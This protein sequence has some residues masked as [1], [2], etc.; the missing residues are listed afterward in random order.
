MA[1]KEAKQNGSNIIIKYDNTTKSVQGQLIGSSANAVFVK[2]N[3]TLFI[4]VYKNGVVNP[5][6]HNINL[7]GNED[8]KMYGNKVGIKKPSNPTVHLYDETGHSAGTTIAR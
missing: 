8:I 3:R 7:T 6:G 1:I 5:C 4:Y 2:N